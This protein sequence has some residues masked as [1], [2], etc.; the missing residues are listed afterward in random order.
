MISIWGFSLANCGSLWAKND[1]LGKL[2]ISLVVG[3][4]FGG[5]GGGKFYFIPLEAPA[6]S[7]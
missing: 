2:G 5:V 7:Q 6:Q 3:R 1:L 4:V